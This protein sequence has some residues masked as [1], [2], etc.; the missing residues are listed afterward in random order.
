MSRSIRIQYPGASYHIMSRGNDGNTIFQNTKDYNIFL[1]TFADVLQDY[2]WICYA[3]CL[4]P[5][6]YHLLVKTPDPNLSMGMRQL[7]GKYT[8]KFNI[9]NKKNGHLF[10][11]RY[12]SLLIDMD[13]YQHEVIRYI[14]LNPVRAKLVKDPSDWLWS[15]HRAMAGIDNNLNKCLHLSFVRNL[16]DHR[17][18]YAQSN[19]LKYLS[20]RIEDDTLRDKMKNGGVLGSSEFLNKV[21]DYFKEKQELKEVPI[22]ERFAFRPELLNLFND[23]ID[24]KIERDENIKMAYSDYGYSLSE[25][26]R[27][28]NLHHS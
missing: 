24:N 1:E 26:G 17:D 6:H 4:M 25:I 5:N 19:Y 3:Y 12:K 22:K 10:Q 9:K 23:G 7:N 27:F 13:S 2:N 15:S 20:D 16:F 8:Q 28:L 14:A 11:G 21:K 18:E